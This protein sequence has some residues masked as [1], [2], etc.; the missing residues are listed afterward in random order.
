MPKEILV[1]IIIGGLLG[2]A[3]AFGVWRANIA[4]SPQAQPS[5]TEATGSPI[6]TGK[7]PTTL[8][9][10][11]T[12]PEDEAVVGEAN[13][14][15]LGLASPQATIAIASEKGETIVTSDN[16]GNFSGVVELSEGTNVIT[17]TAFDSEGETIEKQITVVYSTEVR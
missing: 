2:I 6:P 4:L 12:E 7:T 15:V 9:L 5:Q 14:T 3:I 8:T 10:T 1:A 16:K 13:V 17:V 11:I